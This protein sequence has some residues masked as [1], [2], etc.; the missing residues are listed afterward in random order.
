[1]TYTRE[2][3]MNDGEEFRV[4]RTDSVE[5]EADYDAALAHI[6]AIIKLTKRHFKEGWTNEE[7][8]QLANACRM[9]E[10]AC[11]TANE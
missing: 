6:D 10:A 7:W 8:F 9:I 2:D 4:A 11:K 3:C 5:A 1:M